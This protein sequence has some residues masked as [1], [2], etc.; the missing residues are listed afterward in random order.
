MET[1]YEYLKL[2]IKI[3][4]L[5]LLVLKSLFIFCLNKCKYITF[6]SLFQTS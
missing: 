3:R 2:N 1:G 5:E 6:D 4:I